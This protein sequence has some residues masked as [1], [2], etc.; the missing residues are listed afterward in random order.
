MVI[1]PIAGGVQVLAPAKLN[2]FLEVLGKRPDGY[3]ELETL[4]VAID[5]HDTLSF[6]ADDS[7]RIALKCDDPALPTGPENLVVKA[8]ELLR[9]E[10]GPEGVSRLGARIALSKAIPA[11]AGL[12][13][14]SSDAA[15]TLAAL[16]RLWELNTPADRLREL[17]GQIGSDVSFFLDTPAA[18]CRGRGERV[19]PLSLDP[20]SSPIDFH[21]VLVCPPVGVRTPDV[22]AGLTPPERPEPIGPAIDAFL[23]GDPAR[24]GRRLFNR[25]QPVAE[26]IEPALGRVRSALIDLGPSLDGHLLSGSGSAYFGLARDREA[27]LDAAQR[28]GDLEIGTIRVVRCGP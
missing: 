8:A 22:Y 3:H 5:L 20:E 25:L 16:D 15:A 27:A 26:R 9:R 19:E 24:L 11:Q 4:M 17:A 14:G 23:S 28:L 21:A 6:E 2:L 7:G 10:A 13:G 18:V 1:R 12:G